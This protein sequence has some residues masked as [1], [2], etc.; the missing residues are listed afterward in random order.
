MRL[1]RFC[2]DLAAV[3]ITS[4]D[5]WFYANTSL[6]LM[7]GWENVHG[8]QTMQHAFNGCSG[9]TMLDM[10]GLDPS[11]LANIGYAFASCGD[12]QTIYVDGA[13]ALPAACMGLGTF[14]GCTQIQGGNGT[15]YS[16]NATGAAMMVVDAAGTAGYLTGA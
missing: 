8:L 2:A 7:T 4:L 12:L 16:V 6:L 10:T 13:W 15:A 9:I 3:T 14:Y 5:Y 11:A 1:C